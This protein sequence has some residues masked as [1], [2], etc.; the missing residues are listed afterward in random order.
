MKMDT[1][2]NGRA[3]NVFWGFEKKKCFNFLTALAI[4]LFPSKVC[5]PLLCLYNSNQICR[6]CVRYCEGFLKL[7]WSSL[8][9][10]PFSRPSYSDCTRGFSLDFLI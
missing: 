8:C 10:L 1:C 9:S 5:C 4:H 7:R 2:F 6:F 3:A